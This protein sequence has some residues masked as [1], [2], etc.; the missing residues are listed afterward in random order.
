[1]CEAGVAP[2]GL[3]TV[4]FA[5]TMCLVGAAL[6][7]ALKASPELAELRNDE[8]DQ[9]YEE[10]QAMD[11]S[12]VDTSADSARKRRHGQ[13]G[14]TAAKKKAAKQPT[15]SRLD[16]SG[17]CSTTIGDDFPRPPLASHSVSPR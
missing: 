11:T 15:G 7:V 4:T 8:N 1:M 2:L 12:V 14:L 5:P 3:T 6:G 10:F 17:D 16:A 9:H 13:L